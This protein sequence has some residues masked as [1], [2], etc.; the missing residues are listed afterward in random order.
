MI[1]K[2]TP[3]DK[4]P[5]KF[6]EIYEAVKFE[7]A[8]SQILHFIPKSGNALDIGAG[9]GRDANWLSKN[10]LNT[11]ACDISLPMIKE[12]Q[13][14]HKDSEINWKN[15]SLPKLEGIE[16]KFDFIMLSGVWHIFLKMRGMKPS[17]IFIK[18]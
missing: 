8:H 11:T 4:N 15:S 9:S 13:R 12:A 18:S 6:S 5:T 3:Y 17:I 7:E 2:K 1:I 16:D 10:G 14:I